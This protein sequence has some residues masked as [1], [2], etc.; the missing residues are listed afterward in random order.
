MAAALPEAELAEALSLRAR[1]IASELRAVGIDVNCAPMAD[2]AAPGADPIIASRALGAA[3][4]RVARLARAI[5]EATLAGGVLPVVK[6]LPGHGRARA[7]SHR[8]LPVVDAPLDALRAVDFAP[9]RALADLPL[10]MTAHVAFTA[11]DPDA[12]AT[13]SPACIREIREGIGFSGLLMSDDLGMGAL[14]GPMGA[15][16]AAALAA[17]CDVALHCSGERA[18]MDDLIGAVP[19]LAGAAAARAARALAARRAPEP[20]DEAAADARHAALTEAVHA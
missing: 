1:L 3:P 14:S 7:D 20:F 9:F 13:L 18:E 12:P 5:A 10:A 2:V 6:H 15:R 4:G 11:L 19:P 17:G 8:A 16:A